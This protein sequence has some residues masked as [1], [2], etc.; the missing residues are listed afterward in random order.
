MSTLKQTPV[1]IL[2]AGG[3]GR[4]LI[5]Q[6]IAGRQQLAERSQ[7]QINVVAVADSQR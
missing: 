6:I 5:R 4:A 3:V 1:I 2:G 7:Q